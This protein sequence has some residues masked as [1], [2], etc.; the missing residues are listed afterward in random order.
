LT[1]M[2]LAWRAVGGLLE[3]ISSKGGVQLPPS[4][5]VASR[6]LVLVL[7]VGLLLGLGF[8]LVKKGAELDYRMRRVLRIRTELPGIR[9]RYP[10]DTVYEVANQFAFAERFVYWRASLHAFE[11]SPLTGVGPGNT[12]FFFAGGMPS[13]GYHL[14]E[15]R[16]YLDPASPNFPNPKNLWVR[17]L[18]ESGILGTAFYLTW[19][20]LLAWAALQLRRRPGAHSVWLGTFGVLTLIAQLVEGFSLDSYALPQIWIANCLI[21]A[22]ML[23]QERS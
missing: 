22:C 19:L 11:V 21:T 15:T 6:V 8:A 16:S 18:S 14:V 17:L 3:R 2:W 12:G 20:V 4:V 10:F 23:L 5:Q 9:Q 13:Y 1:G 7:I